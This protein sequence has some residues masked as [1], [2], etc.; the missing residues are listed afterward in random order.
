MILAPNA[1]IEYKRNQT[2]GRNEFCIWIFE[3]AFTIGSV[4][5]I[6]EQGGFDSAGGDGLTGCYLGGNGSTADAQIIT[7]SFR[8]I[9]A[10]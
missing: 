5:V 4:E 7:G 10:A 6:I 1:T 8:L 2:Y 3:A 9:K